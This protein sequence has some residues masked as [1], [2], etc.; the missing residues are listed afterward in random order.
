VRSPGELPSI[1]ITTQQRA[2]KS[3]SRLADLDYIAFDVF[4]QYGP[5]GI[6]GRSTRQ[7]QLSERGI[8]K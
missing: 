5:F 3:R 1:S 7:L 2:R 8:R 6:L 4:L